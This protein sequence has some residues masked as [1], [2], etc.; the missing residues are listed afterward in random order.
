MIE[1]FT[2]ADPAHSGTLESAAAAGVPVTPVTSRAAAALAETVTP[3]GL[4]ALCGA[5]DVP[6]AVALAGR[7]RLV[8]VLVEVAE[9]GNAGTVIRI[10]DAAG[11]DAVL[12]AGDAV[13][14]HNGK[15][16]RASTGSLFHLPVA[17]DR[18]VPAV[19]AACRAV[20]LRPV[21]TS[22]AAATDLD[23]A[24]DA[25]LLTGPLALL[26]GNEAHG[27]PPAVLADADA[28]VRVP[29]HGHAE[30]LNLAGAA[31]I[32]LYAAARA[33]RRAGRSGARA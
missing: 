8:A 22:G 33:Q 26:F 9:P 1:L 5:V 23:D 17:R 27:L 11:A 18:D 29:I 3:Q 21:A 24:D 15:C 19:L 6:V 16:V 25:G 30:S 7:P 32:C 14:P 28:A 13:D 20:G 31:A 4:I 10:A 2:T 12:L